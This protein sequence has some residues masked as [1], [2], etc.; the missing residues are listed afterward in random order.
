VQ[1]SDKEKSSRIPWQKIFHAFAEKFGWPPCIVGKLTMEQVV[2]YVKEIKEGDKKVKRE[3]KNIKN[4]IARSK[5]K[6][7]RR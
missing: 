5:G 4:K 1:F 7:E 3:A 2:F 6:P